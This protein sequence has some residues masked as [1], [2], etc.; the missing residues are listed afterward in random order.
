MNWKIAFTSGQTFS[1]LREHQYD[2]I[3]ANQPYVPRAP[4]EALPDTSQNPSTCWLSDCVI[5]ILDQAAA[6]LKPN[7]FLILELGE[8]QESL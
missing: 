5:P 4:F 3:L 6:Y 7:G 2:F 8:A 1:N